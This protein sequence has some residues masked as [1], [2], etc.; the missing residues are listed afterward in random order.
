[1]AGPR[2]RTSRPLERKLP[3]K[4][5]ERGRVVCMAG[6]LEIGLRNT[7]E[8]AVRSATESAGWDWPGLRT[9]PRGGLARRYEQPGRGSVQEAGEIRDVE[10]GVPQRSAFLASGS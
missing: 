2:P 4:R 1:M 3:Q 5:R 8:P 6:V 7:R 9:N 10:E